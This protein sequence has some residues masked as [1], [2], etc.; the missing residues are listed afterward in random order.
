M[1]TDH[2]AATSVRPEPVEGRTIT[3]PAQ[4]LDRPIC[5][6]C[7]KPAGLLLERPAPA[8]YNPVF[9]CNGRRGGCGYLWSPKQV[10]HHPPRVSGRG[11]ATADG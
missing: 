4:P 7:R 11:P 2:T 3:P 10:P 9:R 5:P 6:R 8:D 1:V